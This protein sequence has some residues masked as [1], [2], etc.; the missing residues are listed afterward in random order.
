MLVSRLVVTVVAL[1][2]LFAMHGLADH[3]VTGHGV[4]GH[5]TTAHAAAS[6]EA[7]HD[8]PAPSEPAPPS[9]HDLVELCLALLA[10]S[11]LLLVGRGPGQERRGALLPAAAPL[12]G[13]TARPRTSDPPDLVA[14][15][16]Q[17]C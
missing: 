9:T 11:L 12:R 4:T 6:S 8:G 13:G 17:R 2:G 16:V 3:G 1:A 14:L 15:C 10:L 7:P 5:G